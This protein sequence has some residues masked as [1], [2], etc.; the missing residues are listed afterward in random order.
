[1]EFKFNISGITRQELEA[2]SVLLSDEVQ[3]TIDELLN[4]IRFK[5]KNRYFC[6]VREDSMYAIAVSFPLSVVRQEAASRVIKYFTENPPED[7][8]DAYSDDNCKEIILYIR[9]AVKNPNVIKPHQ[10]V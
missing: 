8:I 3:T 1:M 5:I 7:F 9:F 4:A 6:K 2:N 10:V